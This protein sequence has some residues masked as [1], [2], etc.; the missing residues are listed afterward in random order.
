MKAR[1]ASLVPVALLLMGSLAF[2]Q[3]AAIAVEASPLQAA[4]STSSSLGSCFG[5]NH[6]NDSSIPRTMS[7]LRIA[8]VQPILTSTP[9]SQ[10]NSGS[11]YAFYAKE[12]GVNANVT[13]NLNLLSTSLSSGYGFNKGW[14]LSFKM[15]QFF[16][17]QAAASCGL[18]IG[19]NV[20][21][22]TDLNVSQGALFYPQ[23]QA[24]RFDVVV[25]PFS[26]YV[27]AQEYVAFEEFVAVGGTLVMMAHSL[28]YP[29][30]YDATTNVESLVYGHGWA[31]NGRYAYPVPCNSNAYV[32]SCPW[33]KNS[34]DWIGSNT[35]EA[36]CYHTYKYNGSVVNIGDPIGRALANEFG[37]KAFRSYAAHEE[38]TV[39]NMT[40]TSVVSAFVND[41]KNLI[42]AYTHHFKKGLVVCMGIFG[43]DIIS[44]DQSAQYFLL[45]GMV[46]GT[47]VP[48]VALASTTTRF[49]SSTTAGT[50]SAETSSSSTTATSSFEHPPGLTPG[51]SQSHGPP[52]GFL[53]VLGGLAV[54][55]AVIGVVALRRRQ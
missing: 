45:L 43:D 9:Y 22:L 15:Y 20:Q 10:Y 7:S 6:V 12:L 23:S 36:S 25:L 40:G 13:T 18:A 34:T 47:P 49:A 30:T 3:V 14:G 24:P 5:Y 26:E 54:V 21:V 46:S 32:E 50:R 41:S 1:R 44:T 53:M 4:T 38:N 17:S 39:M 2:P 52:S 31:F 51:A 11:F 42:A 35:C 29:V 55:V 19:R 48:T 16:T 37:A 33:A 8:L 28:E 27:I